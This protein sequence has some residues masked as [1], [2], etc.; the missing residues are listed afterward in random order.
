MVQ[1][2]PHPVARPPHI[3]VPTRHNPRLASVI[4]RVNQDQELWTLWR[5]ANVNAVERLRISDHGWV[6]VQIV[7]NVALKMLR[8]LR[9]AGVQPSVVEQHGLAYEDAEVVVV[10]GAL[11]HDVGICVHRTDHERFSVALAWPKLRELLE[12]LYELEPRTIVASE[13]LHAIVAHRWD[14][15]CLSLEAGVVKVGDALD[16][17]RGRTRIPFE[18]GKLD[19]H[20]VSA[21]AIEEVSVQRGERK[22]IR[23]DVRLTDAAGI[24]QLDEL[25]KRKLL[26]SSIADQVEVIA[27]LETPAERRIFE[28]YRI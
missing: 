24:F 28:Y 9:D 4:E 23:V 13:T 19:I 5:C 6:H 8:C 10:L 7:A 20:S 21:M 12:G 22:P 16:M 11:L 14:L 3:R 25:L 18:A 26:H 17:A 2:A 15:R 27:H 1:A